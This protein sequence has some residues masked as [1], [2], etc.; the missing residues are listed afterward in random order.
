MARPAAVLLEFVVCDKPL[1]HASITGKTGRMSVRSKV[2]V[3]AALLMTAGWQPAH[4][5]VAGA[6]VALRV[7]AYGTPPDNPRRDL[8][9]KDEV[10]ARELLET[11]P[12]GALHVRLRDDSMLRLGS[13]TSVVVDDFLYTPDAS[14]STLLATI[15]KGVCRFISGKATT[16]RLEVST[17]AATIAA[18][19]T[20]FSVWIKPDGSTTVWVQS[21]EVEVTP[22]DGS[23][24]ALVNA[25]E[26]VLAPIAGGGVQL[27]ATRPAPDPGIAD[28]PRVLIPRRKGLR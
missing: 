28:T 17:P 16:H 4:A 8:F 21:G 15:S 20:E 25:G 9:L 6:V 27:N 7:W 19:G 23:P 18:R 24:P 13:A 26:I 1:M 14:T 22:R 12:Q 11:A 10:Y 2:I 5:E 3:L